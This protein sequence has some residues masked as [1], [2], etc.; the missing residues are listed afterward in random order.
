MSHRI[1]PIKLASSC[2]RLHRKNGIH[3]GWRY[4]KGNT[5]IEPLS[6]ANLAE[7]SDAYL[8]RTDQPKP[9]KNHVQ[10]PDALDPGSQ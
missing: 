2:R 7:F 4:H 6:E 8:F 3:Y 5:V 1:S 10:N 9:A